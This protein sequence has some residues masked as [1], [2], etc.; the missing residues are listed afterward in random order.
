M[1][2][3]SI[4]YLLL[5]CAPT[6]WAQTLP[7]TLAEVR[8]EG[9]RPIKGGKLFQGYRVQF[10]DEADIALQRHTSLAEFV[11]R[12]AGVFLKSNGV[13]S[14]ATLNIRGASAA[15]NAVLWHGINI[16]NP[17]LGA[18]DISSMPTPI[19]SNIALLKGS[20]TAILGNGVVG[21][22]LLLDNPISFQ[23]QNKWTQN[24]QS[25]SINNHSAF[26]QQQY[27]NNKVYF[28]TSLYGRFFNNSFQYD[29]AGTAQKMEH[30]AQILGGLQ[31]DGAYLLSA[32]YKARSYL[33]GHYWLQYNNRKI[34]MA[35]FENQAGKSTVERSQKYLIQYKTER[36]R[37][38][39]GIKAG[40]FK[41]RFNYTDSAI[42]L[43]N[44]YTTH[45]LHGHIDWEHRVRGFWLKNWEKSMS[46]S[47]QSQY[48]V[49]QAAQQHQLMR[50]AI[51]ASHFVSA[52]SKWLQAGISFRQ[53]YNS[54][55]WAPFVPQLQLKGK[56]WQNAAQLV[57]WRASLAR[58]YR[59]PT[60]NEWY[61][62]PGGNASLRP[63]QGWNKELGL[64]YW[65]EGAK[66]QWKMS[67]GYFHRRIDDW[68][69]WMGGAIWTPHNIASVLS[70][71]VEVSA[72]P[73][74][75]L[76]S[77]GLSLHWQTTVLQSVT[78]QS[79]IT[80]DNSIGK[81]IPYAPR[82]IHA[83]S[84]KLNYASWVVLLGGQYIGYRFITTDESQFLE[85][86]LTIQFSLQKTWMWK[87]HNIQ[88]QLFID[89]VTNTTYQEVNG[90]PMP[91][92]VIGA[93]VNYSL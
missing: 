51:I 52:P 40:Y 75:Q 92:R 70:Q 28:K 36:N 61:Y 9:A 83:S 53:E 54:R 37:S 16:N 26:V 38:T 44:A 18:T 6:V 49:L 41:D 34:P 20:N 43:E 29:N 11:Q 84:L 45:Q 85:D 42:S 21:G 73:S 27:S 5:I 80:N 30:A 7:D 60:L 87:Q 76:G 10:F 58:T 88:F 3:R 93:S 31:W 8:A 46:L 90:R 23:P 74:I 82:T 24:L 55:A 12:N 48:Q 67:A 13:N 39:L 81:Q 66:I 56:V 77:L 72:T 35:L 68:I 91:R 15:Q 4:L 86:Y 65:K 59:L 79:Y 2:K 50:F 47:F 17:S 69:I 62:F 71:G 14:S 25:N 22:A 89:N 78:K 32:N 57:N 63:E 64:D 19:F 1:I 33:S